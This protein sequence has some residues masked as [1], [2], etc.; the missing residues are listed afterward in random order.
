MNSLETFLSDLSQ[1]MCETRDRGAV[2]TY[3]PGLAKIDP[4]Q[5]GISLCLAD[6]RVLSYGDAQTLFS[7]QSISKV[8]NLAIALGRYG[9]TLWERVG[10]EPSSNAFNSI[11]ELELENGIPRNPFVN[12][13]AIVTVDALLQGRV[14]KATLADVVRFIRT[15]ASDD[16]IYINEQIARD[17]NETGF[18][19]HSLGYFLRSCNNLHNPHDQVLGTYFH[20]CAIEMSCVQLALAGRFLAG[21]HAEH[22]LITSRH[23][24]SINAL[25][26]SAGHYNG[27]GEFAYQVG[28]PAKSGVG[29]GILAVVP[30]V[31][32][33]AVWS[34]GLNRF[35]NSLLGTRALE[36]LSLFTGWSLFNPGSRGQKRAVSAAS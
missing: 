31:A 29:G 28:F 36:E 35:G 2:A 5:F 11:I 13:G 25:M 6:G 27:S 34:P 22:Q 21:L 15:A 19:N 14:P 4:E 33:I 26:M 24:R 30:G 32:S 9:N 16:D 1:R 12:A 10:R 8:F 3:I 20:L 23:V 7:I 18:R 17:E